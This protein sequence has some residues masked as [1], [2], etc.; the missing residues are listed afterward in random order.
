MAPKKLWVF[1]VGHSIYAWPLCLSSLF[2]FIFPLFFSSPHAF[3]VSLRA[4]CVLIVLDFPMAAKS[5][6]SFETNN[7]TMKWVDVSRPAFLSSG[8]VALK[9]SCINWPIFQEGTCTGYKIQKL[10]NGTHYKQVSL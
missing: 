10:Q 2:L 8:N 3:I 9:F 5:D 1:S 4:S 6:L 7:N